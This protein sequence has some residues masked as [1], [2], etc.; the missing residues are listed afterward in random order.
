MTD[1]IFEDN[2]FD[3]IL[4]S[5]LSSSN[6]VSIILNATQEC[7]DILIEHDRIRNI[8][9]NSDIKYINH[10]VLRN[11]GYSLD[12]S[13]DSKFKGKFLDVSIISQYRIYLNKLWLKNVQISENQKLVIEF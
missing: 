4:N 9:L 8:I 7:F 3:A 13:L 1:M 10:L 11:I 6:L 5:I 2:R 12:M